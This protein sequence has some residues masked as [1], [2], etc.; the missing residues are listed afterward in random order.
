MM[1]YMTINP[2]SAGKTTTWEDLFDE[3]GPDRT[4]EGDVEAPAEVGQSQLRG[5]GPTPITPN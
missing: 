3:K 1:N 5:L 4:S 2:R